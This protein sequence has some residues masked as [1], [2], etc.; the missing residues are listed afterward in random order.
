MVRYSNVSFFG[1]VEDGYVTKYSVASFSNSLFL[2]FRETLS[3]KVEQLITLTAS[4]SSL[5]SA[6]PYYARDISRQID[7]EGW[8]ILD[9]MVQCSP[10]LDPANCAVCLRL[11]VQGTSQCCHNARLAHIFLPKCFLKYDTTGTPQSGSSS[12]NVLQ[13]KEIIGRIFITAMTTTLVLA[14]MGI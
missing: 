3:K 14:L 11:A 13:G 9:T 5:S 1:K 4:K 6:T 8:Y 7:L 12:V 2:T 10:D